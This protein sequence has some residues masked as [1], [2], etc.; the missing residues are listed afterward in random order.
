MTPILSCSTVARHLPNFANQ[1]VQFDKKYIIEN[2]DDQ[3]SFHR[4][5]LVV[6]IMLVEGLHKCYNSFGYHDA[7]FLCVMLCIMQFT[8]SD[9]KSVFLHKTGRDFHTVWDVRDASTSDLQ[10][11]AFLINMYR[12]VVQVL[13]KCSSQY[14]A[15]ARMLYVIHIDV[16]EMV[17]TTYVEETAFSYTENFSHMK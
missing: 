2:I 10:C 15:N 8:Y 16:D 5:V 6:E 17:I 12:L 1:V 11:R 13:F 14:L 7:Y 9:N 4:S 3:N